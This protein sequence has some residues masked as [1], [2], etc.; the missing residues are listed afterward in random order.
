MSPT[1]HIAMRAVYIWQEHGLRTIART[2]YYFASFRTFVFRR[3][4]VVFPGI[5]DTNCVFP[6]EGL[7]A[8]SRMRYNRRHR[9]PFTEESF[10]PCES[11]STLVMGENDT[12]H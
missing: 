10:F 6:A 1:K 11:L 12:P 7:T 4:Q 2:L 3:K 5:L 9:K 8:M